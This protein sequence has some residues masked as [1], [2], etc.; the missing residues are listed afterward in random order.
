LSSGTPALK[1]VENDLL[2]ANKT[3]QAAYMQF[4]RERYA[5]EES[6]IQ[7]SYQ[8]TTIEDIY[9]DRKNSQ[10]GMQVKKKDQ[11]HHSRMERLLLVGHDRREAQHPSLETVLQF[12]LGPVPWSLAT[13][14]G[15]PAKTEKSRLMHCLEL[16]LQVSETPAADKNI[17][18]H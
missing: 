4:V 13:S 14:D 5:G 12:P 2:G 15:T 8:E 11:T 9:K 10:S 16:E 17:L 3:E 6:E 18:Y 1:E 7:R